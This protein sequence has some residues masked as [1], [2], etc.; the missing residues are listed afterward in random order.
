MPKQGRPR[1]SSNATISFGQ[2]LA[3]IDAL[4]FHDQCIEP[5]NVSPRFGVP[6]SQPV[7]CPRTELEPQKIVAVPVVLVPYR[8]DESWGPDR[9]PQDIKVKASAVA[10]VRV[11]PQ[12]HSFQG[13]RDLEGSVLAPRGYICTTEQ[14]ASPHRPAAFPPSTTCPALNTLLLCSRPGV[15]YQV[16]KYVAIWVGG[17]CS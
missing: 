8:R 7:R 3:P 14:P 1:R 17:T 15:D 12:T 9:Y 11:F 16:V 4:D 10:A 6:A 5:R 13:R 2:Q